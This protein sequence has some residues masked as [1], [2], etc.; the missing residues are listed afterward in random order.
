MTEYFGFKE[1]MQYLG[2]KSHKTLNYYIKQGL[3]V[4][5]FG[6]SK[7]ISKTAIDEFMQAHTVQVHPS[8]EVVNNE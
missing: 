2:I 3:P 1:A 8:K 6:N 5:K 7:R 4:I